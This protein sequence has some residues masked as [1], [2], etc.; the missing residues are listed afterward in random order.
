MAGEPTVESA[1]ARAGQIFGKSW[2]W[3]RNLASR[4]VSAFG[5]GTRP[6]QRDVVQFLRADERFGRAQRIYAQGLI[7]RNW[8]TESPRMLTSA[9]AQEWDIPAIESTGALARWFELDPDDLLWFADLGALT[10]AKEHPRLGHYH[11][12][13]LT[14]RS[15]HIRLIEAPKPRL[16]ALQRQILSGILDKIPAHAAAH[17]F[18]KERSIHTFVAPHVGQR[19]ILRMD[20]RDFFP[21]FSGARIQTFF[22]TIGYPEP[23]A[24]LLG[25]ICTTAAPHWAWKEAALDGVPGELRQARDYYARPHLPQGSPASPALANLC[26]Y[27][28]DCR[29]AGLARSMGAQY[30]RYADDLGFSGGAEFDRGVG[31]FSTHVAAILIE[32]GLQVH[33][34]KTHVMRQGVR[35]HLAG[36]VTNHRANV[37]RDEF[38]RL[39]AILTNCAR[40]GPESQN[41]MGHP[42]FRAHLEGKVS[43]VES[44]N[45]EKGQRLRAI[46]DRIEWP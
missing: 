25:G 8:L 38:D 35:Q 31:R 29:L 17:G 22:R 30:T 42:R 41:R 23:V 5:T 6:R 45:S 1:S 21:S 11:Y 28:V 36:L 7:V 12:R 20:L 15:G 13:V 18:V 14:K 39:K 9:P 32:H 10:Y 3:L 19:V 34:H 44:V 33:H 26:M 4:Y 24:D 43:F 2:R 16:K 46:L 27:R 37:R 40:L